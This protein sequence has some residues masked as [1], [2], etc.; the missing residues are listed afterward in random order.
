VNWKIAFRCDVGPTVGVGHV[1]R[2]LALAEEFADRG[3]RVVFVCDA[4]SVPWTAAQIETRGFD[5]AEAVD[6]VADHVRLF[7]SLGVGGVVFDSY[8]LPAEVYRGVREIGLPTLAL[9]DNELRGAE[10]DLLLD[11]NIG[12]ETDDLALPTGSDRLGGLRYAL[13]RE[14]ILRLRPVVPPEARETNAPRVLAVLGGTDAHGA[15]P[16]VADALVRTG[17]P[18][19]AILITREDLFETVRSIPTAEDQRI[20]AV[21]PLDRFPE[22][23]RDADLVVSASG[24]SVWELLSL[25]APAALLRVADNQKVSYERIIATGAAAGLGSLED[26]RGPGLDAGVDTLG[27]LLASAERRAALGAVAWRL[28]DGQGRVRVADRFLALR[29][30]G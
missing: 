19:Q 14:D 13:L 8:R 23:V 27:G 15:A 16:V 26:L 20:Q 9:V 1:M 3:I 17:R 25:G 7:A 11:Q 24:S 5:L 6:G 29:R 22:L 12:S 30:R 21:G 2:S 4:A 18:F 28:V 10:A